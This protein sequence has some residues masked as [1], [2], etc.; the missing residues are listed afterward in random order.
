MK[1]FIFAALLFVMLP[2]SAQL[3]ATARCPEM[4]VDILDGHINR[5][6]PKFTAGE[7]KKV[8]PC[9]TSEIEK[10]DST[11]C[12]GVFIKDKGLSFFTDRNYIEITD[13]YK[14]K[15]EPAVMGAQRG[16]LFK[17]LGNASIKDDSWDA[18][19]TRYGTL[20]LYYNTTGKVNKIQMSSR[21]ADY[22]KL[23]N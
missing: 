18:F 14:G 22:I 12:A 4:L 20:I 3:K 13:V 8:F 11:A 6:S 9:Y 10:T 15:M 21:A 7:I 23:C 19:I 17:F 5:V 2:A 1:Y 16:S